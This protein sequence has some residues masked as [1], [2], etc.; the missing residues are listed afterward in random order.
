MLEFC[1]YLVPCTHKPEARALES[2]ILMQTPSIEALRNER[3]GR[4]P[5]RSHE[6]GRVPA[7]GSCSDGEAMMLGSPPFDVHLRVQSPDGEV[8]QW[9]GP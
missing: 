5:V 2:F 8:Q 9:H 4:R 1:I 6:A 3:A 7:P